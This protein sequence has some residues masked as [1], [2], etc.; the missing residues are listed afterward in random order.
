MAGREEIYFRADTEEF[1]ACENFLATNP[2]SVKHVIHF[3]LE[4]HIGFHEEEMGMGFVAYANRTIWQPNHPDSPYQIVRA[5][6][7]VCTPATNREC[8]LSRSVPVAYAFQ[9]ISLNG[10]QF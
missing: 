3:H 5:S 10:N 6:R 2:F 7:L 4:T 8:V 9:L 1:R